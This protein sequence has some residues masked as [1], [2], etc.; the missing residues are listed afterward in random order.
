MAS[1]SDKELPLPSHANGKPSRFVILVALAATV[2]GVG[3]GIG[4]GIGI[5]SQVFGSSSSETVAAASTP[6]DSK[7]VLP[8]LTVAPAVPDADHH[9]VEDTVEDTD[10]SAG[11]V[12]WPHTL[13]TAGR[14]TG[15]PV[16]TTEA[17]EIGWIKSDEPCNPLL[18]EAY[19]IGGERSLNTSA[20]LYFTP[21]VGDSPGVLSAIEVDFY[22][23]VEES[24][25]GQYLSEEKESKDGPYHSVAV[26][27][28]EPDEQGVCDTKEPARIQTTEYLAFGPGMAN[29]VVPVR[30]DSP[31]LQ[32]GWQQG[33]CIRTMG[34][35]YMKDIVGVNELTHKAE[36]LV[37][38]VPMY[39][40]KDGSLNG[41]FFVA[42][43]RKQNWPDDC[44]PGLY[45]PCAFPDLNFW[46]W[47]PG[48]TEE[49]TADAP[50]VCSNFCGECPMTGS[51]DGMYTTMHWM[52]KE[53]RSGP[54][55]ETCYNP[56]MSPINCRSN[57]YPQ[58]FLGNARMA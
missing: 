31:E 53:T 49:T 55:A 58:D 50:Y 43:G 16:T 27:L 7:T 23:Y 21:E 39:S 28:R 54:D 9:T 51:P 10:A 32:S 38:I 56:N 5:G 25:V 30:E 29:T 13:V 26:A 1:T 41:L 8:S 48:L 2:I 40:S 34:Y 46:D 20:T 3:I 45:A 52:F 24:L 37:P 47:S 6:A 4:I 15:N 17:L 22:G 11:A 18:G 12:N 19:L 44:P 36:N 14:M 42:S 35:H 57:E 33:A